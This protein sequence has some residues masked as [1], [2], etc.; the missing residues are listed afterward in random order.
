MSISGL[1]MH[2]DAESGTQ[3][4]TAPSTQTTQSPTTLQEL[5]TLLGVEKRQLKRMV[6]ANPNDMKKLSAALQKTPD[7]K[8]A[9]KTERAID[10]MV[11]SSIQYSPVVAEKARVVLE[12]KIL[13]A[14]SIPRALTKAIAEND[15]STCEKQ[16]RQY[17]TK[18]KVVLDKGMNTQTKKIL[19]EAQKA[20]SNA[21]S[22][23]DWGQL[24]KEWSQI[25]STYQSGKKLAFYEAIQAEVLQTHASVIVLTPP[26][27]SLAKGAPEKVQA[28]ARETK[29]R[30]SIISRCMEKL[31]V[32]N[33]HANPRVELYLRSLVR[34]P[35]SQARIMPLI[36]TYVRSTSPNAFTE[37]VQSLGKLGI[38]I[39]T[40][41]TLSAR[42]RKMLGLLTRE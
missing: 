32:Q 29:A 17:L 27:S 1:G 33:P 13:N 28:A 7:I 18:L 38:H 42:L 30:T 11:S 14:V 31:R 24:L 36:T 39:D 23:H 20:V 3:A 5:S 8:T 22:T 25:F 41:S 40:D 37:M 16:C 4:Y 2:L 12:A 19:S 35:E 6:S 10:K 26:D 21:S 34:K 15:N 9:L